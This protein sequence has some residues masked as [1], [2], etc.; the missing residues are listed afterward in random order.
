VTQ[1]PMTTTM[2]IDSDSFQDELTN[3]ASLLGANP[4]LKTEFIKELDD[5]VTSPEHMMFIPDP[6][7]S[8]LGALTIKPSQ[9][10]MTLVAKMHAM[11]RSRA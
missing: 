4:W 5:L 8:G 9:S 1:Q 3:L 2:R 7:V 6:S 11:V 10:F